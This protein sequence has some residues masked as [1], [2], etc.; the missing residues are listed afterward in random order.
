MSEKTLA[1]SEPA[2]WPSGP[3]FV[4]AISWRND[5]AADA[6]AVAAG[7]AASGGKF[8]AACRP[9]PGTPPVVKNGTVGV[10]VAPYLPTPKW[11]TTLEFRTAAEAAAWG[12]QNADRFDVIQSVPS[13]PAQTA[14]Q[15]AE[16]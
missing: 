12:A 2:T 5:T 14:V 6:E 13:L 15:A 10:A 8:V 16:R 11:M 9:C 7:L 3:Q 4:T 1:G